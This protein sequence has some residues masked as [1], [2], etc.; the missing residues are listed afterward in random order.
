MLLIRARPWLLFGSCT[1][2]ISLT[3]SLYRGA[4]KYGGEPRGFKA[5][6]LGS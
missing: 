2:Q 1:T 4:P 6:T 3:L 5:D